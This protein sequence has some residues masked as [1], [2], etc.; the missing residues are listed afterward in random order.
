MED[1]KA[2]KPSR[3]GRKE[4]G[5]LISERLREKGKPTK[6]FAAL[7]ALFMD[8]RGWRAESRGRRPGRKD[9]VPR[10]Q[11]RWPKKEPS[12]DADMHSLVTEIESHGKGVN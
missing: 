1:K 5:A 10:K 9:S 8:L 2:N 12:E 6:E 4:L 3:I 7:C 11:G